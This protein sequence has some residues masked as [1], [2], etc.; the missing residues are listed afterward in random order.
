MTT[1]KITYT[2]QQKRKILLACAGY[3]FAEESLALSGKF[4]LEVNIIKKTVATI[5]I[6]ASVNSDS[7]PFLGS[8][9]FFDGENPILAILPDGMMKR[10]IETIGSTES[11]KATPLS[12][13]MI[14]GE[15]KAID[16]VVQQFLKETS[17]ILS[18]FEVKGVEKIAKFIYD[19]WFLAYTRMQIISV[20]EGKDLKEVMLHQITFATE[21]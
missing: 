19:A 2:E 13:I 17:A 10:L 21:K 16:V 3:A 14:D 18:S 20:E 12:K 9:L 7:N 8:H 6:E 11:G 4:D 5:K 1:E 15:Y